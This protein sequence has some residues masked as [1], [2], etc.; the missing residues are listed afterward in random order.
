MQLIF[1]GGAGTVTGSCYLIEHERGR[2]LIDCGMFQGPKSVRELNYR[3][4]PF[5]PASVD[6]LLLTHAH[7]DHSGLVP[8][9]CKHGFAGPVHATTPTIDLASFMLP[10]SGHIQE[11]EVERLNRRNKKRG[12]A[13]VE[14]I[15]TRADA[16]AC[17]RQMQG[18]AYEKWLEPAPGVRARFWNAGHILGSASIELQV[19]QGTGEPP[20]H[21]LFS[22]DLGPDEKVFH[23][24]PDAP[25]GFDYVV[26]ESTY[27][28]R[29]RA[30]ATVEQR[31]A[32]L[33]Q[34]INEALAAGGNLLIPAFAVERTQELLH[35]IGVLLHERKIP[36]GPVFLDS[37][38]AQNATEVFI[39]HAAALED[40]ALDEAELFRNPHF[41]FVES[42]E[43]SKA[44]NRITAGAIIIAASGM[45]EAGRIRHH[46][47]ANLWRPQATVLMVGYQ[48]PGTLGAI[49]LSGEK[50]VR[51][52]GEEVAVKARIRSIGNYS[53]HADQQE[54]VAWVKERQPVHAGIFLT[55]GEDQAR[56]AL[57]AELQDAGI[58][59]PMRL[60]ALDE[61]FALEAAAPPPRGRRVAE[62]VEDAQLTQDWHN[63]YARLLLGLGRTLEQLPDD[64]ARRELLRRMGNL[65]RR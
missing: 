2:F 9:L 44:I 64:A 11:S 57:R 20:I 26:C 50:L 43:E 10:D 65:L 36:E 48:A 5:R 24:E 61:A 58:G 27:G 16:E 34:E 33:C 39:R 19:A 55:H 31:R 45:C 13:T 18:A 37:P 62:R 22:G 53:A 4:F 38:L 1:H 42:V 46:L 17:L 35:D 12:R 15:Y 63:D 40:I 8:K 54:L 52:M 30:D 47:K 21:L 29:D 59:A 28:D 7:I 41:R 23:L 60:P 32:V 49:L 51:M 25:A 6:F 14:P 3:P 56:E